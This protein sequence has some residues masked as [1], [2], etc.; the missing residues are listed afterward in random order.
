M[1]KK[2]IAAILAF[3][4]CALCAVGLSACGGS[5]NAGGLGGLPTPPEQEQPQV[6]RYKRVDGEGNESETGDYILFGSYPQSKVTDT[7]I[8]EALNVNA[9]T[10]PE[11]GNNQNWISYGYY[12]GTGSSGT[13]SNSTD[14][15]W[16]QDVNL[17]GVDYRGVYFTNYRPYYTYFGG[18]A[19]ASYQYENGYMTNTVY[20]FKYEPIQWRI[21]KEESGYATLLCEMI[22]DS[23]QYDYDGS[24][25]NNYM[26]STIRAWLAD[27][28]YATAFSTL[29]Q[30]IIQTVTVD[31]SS[32]STGN[33]ANQYACDNTQ[34]KVWL[35][36]YA[37]LVNEQY[38]FNES[39]SA[40][41]AAR[42]K[43]STD[44]AKSQG[45]FVYGGNSDWW[46]RSPYYNNS[47]YTRDVCNDGTIYDYNP[48][49]LTNVGVVPSLQIRL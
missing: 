32:A 36:S 29:E 23:Q 14:Y 13:E 15:M 3:L 39:H 12:K 20:W 28:F 49:N 47:S 21:L 6:P 8:A 35:L 46:L 48:V 2:L 25:N 27:T 42:Q 38:G 18:T 19:S 34:D 41:D 22:I 26:E 4:T 24:Y 11:N 40:Y 5:P 45:A 17:N 43:I 10:L 37:D 44:Y 30:A 7:D 31:N 9:G 16:Y 1:T 33:D